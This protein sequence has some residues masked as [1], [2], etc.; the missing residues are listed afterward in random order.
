LDRIRADRTQRT[1]RQ[2]RGGALAP[3][4]Q[5]GIASALRLA[6]VP[7]D[8]LGIRLYKCKK[9]TETVFVDVAPAS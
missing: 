2:K 8:S 6:L 9:L 4:H 7:K 3:T 5:R 1:R